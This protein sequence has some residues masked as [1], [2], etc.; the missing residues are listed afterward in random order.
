MQV[1]IW[2]FFDQR[3]IVLTK[4]DHR[5]GTTY[6]C[7]LFNEYSILEVSTVINYNFSITTLSLSLLVSLFYSLLQYWYG[8]LPYR[9]VFRF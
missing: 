3:S 9:A 8:T 7:M 5:S 1:F 4:I 6:I 2:F